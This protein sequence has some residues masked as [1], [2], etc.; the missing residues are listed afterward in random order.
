MSTVAALA[1]IF[2]DNILPLLILMGLGYL[3]QRRTGLEMKTLSRLNMHIFVPALA[4]HALSR[5]E[6]PLEGLLRVVAYVALLQSSLFVVGRAWGYVRGYSVGMSAAF[7]CALIFYNSGNYG[8]PLI[9][10]LYGEDSPAVGFQAIVLAM[11]NLTTFSIGQVIIRG[12]QL[13]VRRALIEYFKM[14]FPYALGLGLVLQQTDW[15]LPTPL[16]R[17]VE[18]LAGG[19]VPLALVTL[20]AQ[21]AL[22]RWDRRVGAV[23]AACVLR[24]VVAPLLGLLLLL[25]FG[26]RGLLAQQLLISAA[27]PTAVN[28]AILAIEFENEPDFAAQAVMLSTLAS[29]GSVTIFIYLAQRLFPT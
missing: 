26:W 20:G 8:Y 23:L 19:L 15:S 12:P 2:R 13:G 17:T 29:A 27:V 28:T 11:Q 21:L 10:L 14:P 5:A 16:A 3:L 1:V 24:L 25:L 6:L 22:V 7:T 4:I 18:I 9:A